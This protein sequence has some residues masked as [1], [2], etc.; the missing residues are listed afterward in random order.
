MT[1]CIF[2]LQVFTPM[3]KKAWAF[4]NPAKFCYY[5]KSRVAWPRQKKSK[6][7]KKWGKKNLRRIA[8]EPDWSTDTNDLTYFGELR[9]DLNGK[10]KSRVSACTTHSAHSFC[11]IPLHYA[12]FSHL[13]SWAPS[14]FYVSLN[15]LMCV[16]AVNAINGHDSNCC[17]H[18]KHA[19]NEQL[20]RFA[21]LVWSGLADVHPSIHPSFWHVMPCRLRMRHASCGTTH[22]PP[23]FIASTP[24][25][26]RLIKI[27]S[28]MLHTLHPALSVRQLVGRTIILLLLNV[29]SRVLRVCM[30]RRSIAWSVSP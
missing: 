10:V 19:L 26:W 29:F 23:P 30:G 3:K 12:R 28:R 8:K 13:C 7:T 2:A 5:S 6:E 16:P 24:S 18:W 27:V 11:S 15:S 1:I 4:E 25:S 20:Q 21:G 9:T 14:L 22:S 17:H